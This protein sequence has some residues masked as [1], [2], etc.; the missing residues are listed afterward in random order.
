MTAAL[1]ILEWVHSTSLIPPG[2][3]PLPQS[4]YGL[5]PSDNEDLT[6]LIEPA[7]T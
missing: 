6:L 1:A 7:Q 5:F 3:H 4:Q 2:G